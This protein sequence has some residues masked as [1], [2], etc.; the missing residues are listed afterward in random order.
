MNRSS[1]IRLLR[2]FALVCRADA[3]VAVTAPA[4][5]CSTGVIAQ[6]YMRVPASLNEHTVA[7][8]EPLYSN[9]D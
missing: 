9:S 6:T 2:A 3:C 4:Y 5:A 1:F 7:Y 8:I